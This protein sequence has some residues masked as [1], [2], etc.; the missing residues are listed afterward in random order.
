[1]GKKVVHF[2]SYLHDPIIW[3]ESGHLVSGDRNKWVPG[4]C[5]L[6]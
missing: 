1:M 6:C 4:R 2:G 5:V 3:S